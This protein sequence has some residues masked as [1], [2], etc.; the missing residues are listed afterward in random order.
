MYILLY[1]YIYNLTISHC[2]YTPNT[3][4]QS[5]ILR[6]KNLYRGITHLFLPISPVRCIITTMSTA[7][8]ATS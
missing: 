6:R 1:T 2:S 3:V 4:K 5:H 8:T 7:T